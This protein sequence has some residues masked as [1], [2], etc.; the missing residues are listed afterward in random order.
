MSCG[1]CCTLYAAHLLQITND[2][3][4][5][6]PIFTRWPDTQNESNVMCR[7]KQTGNYTRQP[8]RTAHIHSCSGIGC[9]NSDITFASARAPAQRSNVA[10]CEARQENFFSSSMGAAKCYT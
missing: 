1:I 10:K 6:W 5:K 3:A 2:N 9:E 8:N 7:V 4:H